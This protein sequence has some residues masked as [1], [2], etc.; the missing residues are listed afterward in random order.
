MEYKKVL[1]ETVKNHNYSIS[2][3][4]ISKEKKDQEY[5][6][7][8]KVERQK[9]MKREFVN[10]NQKI[11]DDKK[12]RQEDESKKHLIEEGERIRRDNE[13]KVKE[14]VESY[15]KKNNCQKYIMDSLNKQLEEKHIHSYNSKKKNTIKL[16]HSFVRIDK[17]IDDNHR[18]L[19][20][21]NKQLID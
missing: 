15:Y 9:A 3:E 14:K 20:E 4:T 10:K 8:V 5:E 17:I 1:K 6:Q 13:D 12:S 21:E 11:L 7:N 2:V 18:N 19:L 16:N